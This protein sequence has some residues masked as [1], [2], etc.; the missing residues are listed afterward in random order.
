MTLK[1]RKVR[2][3]VECDE[4]KEE[5]GERETEKGIRKIVE[6]GIRVVGD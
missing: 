5:E 3:G 2:V 4:S 1:V 6:R